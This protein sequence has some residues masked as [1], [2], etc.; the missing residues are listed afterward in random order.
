MRSADNDLAAEGRPEGG[1]AIDQDRNL[2]FG[3]YAVRLEQ[4][5]PH[6]LVDASVA[7]AADPSRDIADHLVDR[8][9]LC[10]HDR[11][12]IQWVVKR[13]A[14]HYGGDE[15]ATLEHL[16]REDALEAAFLDTVRISD[17]GELSIDDSAIHEVI[18]AFPETDETD[19]SDA[20]DSV[21]DGPHALDSAR[22]F[23]ERHPAVS[24]AMGIVLMG[25]ILF[26]AY[27]YVALNQAR[28][29]AAVAA[30]EASENASTA[31]AQREEAARLVAE[32]QAGE[33]HARARVVEERDRALAQE[34]VALRVRMEEVRAQQKAVPDSIVL[35]H[36]LADVYRD[37]AGIQ[38]RQGEHGVALSFAGRR[39]DLIRELAAHDLGN[40]DLAGELSNCYVSIGRQHHFLGESDKAQAAF[41]SAEALLRESL[42]D[43]PEDIRL[44]NA[45]R[46]LHQVRASLLFDE[47]RFADALKEMGAALETAKLQAGL[48][49]SDVAY[50]DRVLANHEGLATIH[51]KLEQTN[52]A[53]AEF[54]RAYAGYVEQIDRLPVRETAPASV[55]RVYLFLSDLYRAAGDDGR[56]RAFRD[57]Y[58]ALLERL[59]GFPPG[60]EVGRRTL[61][62]VYEA[63][64]VSFKRD[65]H[66][67]NA[68][69]AYRT[70]RDLVGVL[71]DAEPEDEEAR[72]EAVRLDRRLNQLARGR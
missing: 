43:D 15:T 67:Q 46:N 25:A 35:M 36:E 55:S 64:G 65:G 33:A 11:D 72:N 1:H 4:I 62:R 69:A 44:L 42:G 50:L 37:I 61:A 59:A 47:A 32:A 56:H 16:G 24:G 57:A 53:I 21:E 45:K 63:R 54:E 22:A 8:E 39:L 18:E 71:L 19:A 13:A 70:S 5:T 14:E 7:W 28:T 34:L 2:L 58:V 60:D 12:F 9:V 51:A 6:E 41:A 31:L 17:S 66:D 40:P 52:E 27:S 48:Y 29:A 23:L 38:S 26:A 30:R 10:D 49:P 68:L 3:V 20:S